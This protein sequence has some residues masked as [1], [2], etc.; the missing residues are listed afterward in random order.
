MLVW[1]GPQIAPLGIPTLKLERAMVLGSP[2]CGPIPKCGPQA[3]AGKHPSFCSGPHLL[4]LQET[5]EWS[6]AGP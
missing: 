1:P 5:W 3:E 4:D 2:L 6:K